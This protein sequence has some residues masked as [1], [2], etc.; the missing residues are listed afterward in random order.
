MLARL[1]SRNLSKF[2]HS[3]ST[4][5]FQSV[6]NKG[7]LLKDDN[8]LTPALFVD[9][10][11]FEA[12]LLLLKEHLSAFKNVR[13]RAHAKA[14]KTPLL[15][16]KQMNIGG[17]HGVCCQKLSEAIAMANG[18]VT[19][20]LITNEV[21]Q[22]S[23][24]AIIAELSTKIQVG[25]CIDNIH[26]AETLSKHAT[27]LSTNVDAYVDVN[28]GQN[29]CGV[30][31]GKEAA[32][33]ALKISKLPGLRFKGIQ[34]YQG[35][36]QHVRKYEDRVA[37][38]ELVVTKVQE[39]LSALSAVGLSAE[40]VTGGGTGTYELEAASG[41]FTEVQPG[42]YCLMDVDYNANL[43]KEGLPVPRFR[44]SLHILA[45]VVSKTHNDWAVIDVG[46]KGV[47]MDSGAP[48]IHQEDIEAYGLD[49]VYTCGGDEHGILRPS[50]QGQAAFSTL[51]VG[52]KIRLIPGHCDPTCN[53]YD[54]VLA[55]RGGVVEAAFP[56]GGRSPG[57]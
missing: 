14:H 2:C 53:L 45:T 54:E 1:F 40:V 41:V 50:A 24:L 46:L 3:Y 51:K 28:V 21:V 8:V 7:T 11:A 6:L 30:A 13:L 31:P 34:A 52:D 57:I 23:K 33:L 20:I 55:V 56:V 29:R 44:Q 32:D 17:S 9:M 39:T 42:S 38:V 49:G 16:L 12:N 37:A 36:N 48:G 5:A 25:L 35:M 10:D 26:V 43:N 18:G 4:M 19:D 47:S 22:S 15:A 27:A